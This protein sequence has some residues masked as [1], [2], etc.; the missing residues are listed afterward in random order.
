M[1]LGIFTSAAAKPGGFPKAAKGLL[2][3]SLGAPKV[4]GAEVST[5]LIAAV[6]N[7]KALETGAG[8][9]EATGAEL[10][11]TAPKKLGAAVGRATIGAGTRGVAKKSEEEDLVRVLE[12]AGA[13]E[14]AGIVKAGTT[15]ALGAPN[16]KGV[17]A[18]VVVAKFKAGTEVEGAAAVIRLNKLSPG[19]TFSCSTSLVEAAGVTIGG[20]PNENPAGNIIVGSLILLNSLSSIGGR[21]S[22]R[23]EK[24]FA[25]AT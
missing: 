13:L 23:A 24:T 4:S 18:G 12:R 10:A 20:P 7:E 1:L 25:D 15:E 2:G 5:D 9:L 8:G 6:G 11:K 16:E 3:I 21:S 22:S 14:V 19:R 17:A